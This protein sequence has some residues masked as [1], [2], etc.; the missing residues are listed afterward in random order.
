MPPFLFGRIGVADI[1]PRAV[2]CSVSRVFVTVVFGQS[3][4]TMYNIGPVIL[5]ATGE[6]SCGF[7][8][9]CM[10]CLPRVLRES[11]IWCKIRSALGLG[12]TAPGSNGADGGDGVG[13][14]PTK[15]RNVGQ[16]PTARDMDLEMDD[17]GLPL[18]ALK[19]TD[20]TE[21]LRYAS[22]GSDEVSHPARVIVGRARYKK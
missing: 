19:H 16:G 22:D 21:R 17:A 1:Q 6:M 3:P 20:S 14:R 4:D 5:W 12:S 7:F 10:P 15:K 18:H 13:D 2:I 9:A 11:L 8:V